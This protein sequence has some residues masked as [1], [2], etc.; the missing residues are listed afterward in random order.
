[1]TQ[2]KSYLNTTGTVF[3]SE[4]ICSVNYS[5]WHTYSFPNRFKV[6]LFKFYNNLLGT[7]SRVSHFNPNAEVSCSFCVKSLKLPAPIETF[8]H[9][10]YDCPCVFEIVDKFSSKFFRL[11]ITKINY[12]S[13]S[14]CDDT[15]KN[16][17]ITVVLNCL[18]YT[19]W[20]IR[21][22]KINISYSTI[23]H[24]TSL[25]L[26]SITNSDSK[27]KQSIIFNE[28]IDVGGQAVEAVA[29]DQQHQQQRQLH[30]GPPQ[31]VQR[32]GRHP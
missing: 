26:D 6:F 23:E 25:L 21:L 27:I 30:Q 3:I 5:L 22:L 12:F 19:I 8:S 28:F 9:I 32:A 10:F 13:G 31:D 20:Q 16:Y 14:Y 17:G 11:P 2:V 4:K 1:M 29:A 15:M 24:E 18:R 7:G